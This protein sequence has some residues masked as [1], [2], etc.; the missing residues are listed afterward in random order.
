MMVIVL[1][2]KKRKSVLLSRFYLVHDGLIHL[3]VYECNQ[4][5]NQLFDMTVLCIVLY[6]ICCQ[7]TVVLC[8]CALYV[9]A[10][11]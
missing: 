8:G 4:Y 5:F 9:T 7:C 3:E 2:S 10:A 1:E 11:L 6:F